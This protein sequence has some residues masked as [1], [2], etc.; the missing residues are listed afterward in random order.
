M[1]IEQIEIELASIAEQMRP[2]AARCE[3]LNRE[4]RKLLSQ[5]WIAVNGVT[6]A[7]LQLSAG[8]GVPC[9]SMLNN[10]AKWLRNTNC[11]KRFCEW[12]GTIYFTSEIIG[13]RMDPNA[14]GR[15]EDVTR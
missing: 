4:L 12:N 11:T 13:G 5:R 14:T 9:F 15:V 7:N 8:D 10:F 1:T 3:V 6:K 2:L